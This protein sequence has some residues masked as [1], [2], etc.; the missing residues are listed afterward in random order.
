[1]VRIDIMTDSDKNE[2]TRA[3]GYYKKYKRSEILRIDKSHPYYRT[4]N[5]GNISE[6][7]L[8]MAEHLGRNL[9]KDDI[10]YLKDGDVKNTAIDN[11]IVLTKREY[12]NI[13]TCARLE[14]A[15]DRI[16]SKISVYRQR[17]ID[18]GIDPAALDVGSTVAID[19]P[20]GR[21][22][23]LDRDREAK[24]RSRRSSRG[25]IGEYM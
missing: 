10:V 3:P 6:P 16:I 13:Q 25:E 12:F 1:M 24:D 14:K 11:L 23:Q 2:L 7:R 9:T 18:S 21:W 15:R 17:I 4:S 5:K 8:I 20:E 22:R 19:D